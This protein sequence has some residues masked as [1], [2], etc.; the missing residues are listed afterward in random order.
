MTETLSNGDPPKAWVLHVGQSFG[1]VP[2]THVFYPFIESLL[3]NGV[4]TGCGASTFCPEDTVFRLQMAVF[5]A[6]TLAGG[7]GSVPPSGTAQGQAY[8]C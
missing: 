1:D 4:T 3:H 8:D 6:R 7:D 2:K 5:L